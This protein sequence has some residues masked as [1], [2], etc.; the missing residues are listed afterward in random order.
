ME[1][2]HSPM[3]Q[4]YLRIK[5]DHTDKLL[6]YRM[7]DFYELFFEDA[8]R[9]AALLDLT[10]TTRGLSAGEPIPMAGVPYHAVEGYLL[11]LL[12][13]GESVAICEQI[14]DP[15]TSKG[16]VERKVMRIITPGTIT[17][18]ALLNEYHDNV[19][20]A[21]HSDSNA[22]Q[23]H[24]KFGIAMLD[25]TNGRFCVCEVE[26][27][28]LLHSELQ[29]LNPAELLLAENQQS[30][31]KYPV[32]R[33]PLWDFEYK[34]N[35]TLLCQ[36]FGT[37]HLGGFGCDSLT[38]AIQAAGA[39]LRYIQV[40]QCSTQALLHIQS[41]MVE[42]IED[43]I[44]L[45]A[46]TQRNLEIIIN[47]QNKSTNT[48]VAMM[49]KTATPMGT[50]LLKRW[51]L[52]PLRDR[53]LLKQRQIA[54]AQL[55]K[56]S[57]PLYTHLRKIGDM[58][59]IIAR[60]SLRTVRPRDL[61]QLRLALS[62]CP[63]IKHALGA[64]NSPLIQNLEQ[65]I[66]SFDELYNTLQKAL[67]ENPPTLVREGGVI[68]QGYDALLDELRSLHSN[69]GQYLIDLETRE[70]A[71]TQLSSLKVGFNRVHGYYIEISKIQA[72]QAPAD[73]MRRQT[74]K[75]AERFITPELKRFE[76]KVLSS[77]EKALSR[78]K[79]LYE[80]LVEE[81]LQQIKSLQTTANALATLDTLN[82]LAQ[83]ATRLQ[84]NCPEL[85]DQKEIIIE[86]GRHP[87]IEQLTQTPFIPNDIRLDCARRT[88]L[89]TGP[90]MGGKSTY[91]RQTA[92]IVLLAH[93]GSFVPA[94]KARIGLVDR[95]FT[96]IGASDDLASH[97]ST[98][99]VEMTETATILHHATEHSLVLLDE[100]GRGT[101]TF[102]GLSLA[103]ACAT[104]LTQQLQ[105]YV[106]FATHYFELTE[107]AAQ[108]QSCV[109]VHFTAIEHENGIIFL[110]SVQEG[111]A[112]K[113]Y[114]LQ[115][116][117]LAGIPA[118]VLKIAQQKLAELEAKQ[119]GVLLEDA[120]N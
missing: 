18:E 13:R 8:K 38:L 34:S 2:Q 41:L 28:T 12:Q 24:P 73:Y 58:E 66:H 99:M 102:D 65:S 95:I 83:C 5:A 31:G 42:H 100:V 120:M 77:E 104:Y 40:T 49:D 118:A 70:K 81:L 82:N 25:I 23:G 90:N 19:L 101:S 57:E 63:T 33:R 7:G 15:A 6:L 56:E 52:R 108:L 36:Q 60:I 85:T 112:N 109:N 69:A 106:L 61:L 59:R 97:R 26:N 80:A 72:L 119:S 110:H 86:Q 37:Q 16:P 29:R 103:F 21:V 64:L 54:I 96:R 75:N 4:Q 47:L 74:L 98:F 48:L 20:V 107:L 67:V 84:W 3:M 50:R 39:L 89:I 9:A 1:Q 22:K 55:Q 30:V 94:K 88:L 115:V 62:I 87:V 46:T 17:D 117:Q 71:R 27:E 11:K 92:L 78:E 44:L 35:Y 93:I 32:C 116:A 113:S 43:T 51:L 68:A 91:M 10:L 111:A 105:S 114:G 53:H 14:G 45:D 76:D 79:L